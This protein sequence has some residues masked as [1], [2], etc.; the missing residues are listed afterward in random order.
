MFHSSMRDSIILIV[1]TYNER[2]NLPRLLE[3]VLAFPLPK[4]QVLVVDDNSP[5][6]TGTLADELAARHANLHVLHRSA[7]AGLGTAYVEGLRWALSHGAAVIAQMDADFSHDP[8]VLPKLF[9]ALYQGADV[10]LGSRYVPGGRIVNWSWPRRVVSWLGNWYARTVLD[11]PIRDLTGGFKVY[12]QEVLEKI[13]L[14]T[15]SSVGYNFQ[16]ETTARA[17]W[18]GFRV[19]EIPIT[20]TERRTGSSKFNLGIM[21]EA[22]RKVWRLRGERPRR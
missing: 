2:D 1:P 17:V 19:A 7:K 6:G 22:F 20:F 10:A 16:I 8:A 14:A 13:D 9:A 5:D 4:L 11:L 18:R 21:V 12:R 3:Q 15:L